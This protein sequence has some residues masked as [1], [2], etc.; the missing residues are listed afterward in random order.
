MTRDRWEQIERLFQA[1]AQRP[2][3]EHEAFLK[4]HCGGDESLWLE[5]ESLLG[6]DRRGP[7]APLGHHS[8]AWGGILLS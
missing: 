5:V 2:V 1:V 6:S 3:A 7:I 8:A 4:E